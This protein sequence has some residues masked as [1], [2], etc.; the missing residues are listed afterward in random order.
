MQ[1]DGKEK[2]QFQL[3]QN[4]F[5]FL[6]HKESSKIRDSRIILGSGLL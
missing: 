1:N 4:K 6:V 3:Q 5:S 2:T